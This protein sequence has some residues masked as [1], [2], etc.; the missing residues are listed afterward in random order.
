MSALAALLGWL[1]PPGAR[2]EIV[3]MFNDRLAANAVTPAEVDLACEL[4][5]DGDLDAEAARVG[6]SSP[7]DGIAP[8]ALLA[9]LGDTGARERVLHALTSPGEDDVSF[10]QVYLRHRPLDD[11]EELRTLTADIARMPSAQAQ[12]QALHA[13]ARHRLT[14]RDS[15]DTLLRLYPVAE[16][17][18]VQAAIAGILLRSDYRSIAS[19]EVVQT[20]R[21][22]RLRGGAGDDAIDVLIRRMQ[23]QAD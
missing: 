10:A 20:L 19:P 17:A 21:T 6:A 14:D 23:A 2:D 13:L 7:R 4:N 12:V 1:T 11:A 15:L 22:R 18:G 16:T 5:K 3:R 8:S 9:C